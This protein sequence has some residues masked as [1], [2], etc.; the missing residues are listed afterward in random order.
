[1]KVCR[2][3]LVIKNLQIKTTMRYYFILRNLVKNKKYDNTGVGNT[4]SWELSYTDSESINWRNNLQKNLAIP[5]KI[6]NMY[7]SRV[8]LI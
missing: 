6:K 1:M 2:T 4:E 7:S 3:S 8:S 5:S